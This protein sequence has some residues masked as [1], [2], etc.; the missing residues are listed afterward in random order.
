MAG[1]GRA[2]LTSKMTHGMGERDK[3]PDF[4]S[5]F[6]DFPNI[7]G[8]HLNAQGKCLSKYFFFCFMAACDI[9]FNQ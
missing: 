9:K 2:A 4:E 5:E 6:E 1:N 3:K 7:N 8:G